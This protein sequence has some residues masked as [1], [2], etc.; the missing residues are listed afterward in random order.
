MRMRIKLNC[1]ERSAYLAGKAELVN[2]KS[3]EWT[4]TVERQL[5]LGAVHSTTRRRAVEPAYQLSG[6]LRRTRVDAVSVLDVSEPLSSRRPSAWQGPWSA[7]PSLLRR[8]AWCDP[9]P[10]PSPWLALPAHAATPL[11][12]LP[13]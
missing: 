10:A 6:F 3:L 11:I 13:A 2:R 1:T 9:V 4:A 7:R 5:R 12:F 8:S